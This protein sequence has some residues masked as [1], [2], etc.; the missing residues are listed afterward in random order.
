M[1][2]K[3]TIRE[4][5]LT[6]FALKNRNTVLLVILMIIAFGVLSYDNLPKELFPDVKFPTI[7]VQTTYPGNPPE[8]IENLITR[9]LEKELKAVKGIKELRSISVQD[10]SMIFVEFSFDKE[11]DE[12]LADVKDEVDKVLS[13]LPNDLL[14]DPQ[15][16]DV[17]F[18][19]FPI[20]NINLSGDFSVDELKEY[21]DYLQDELETIYEVSK[22]EM[23]GINEKE[24]Q[25][26][27]NPHKLDALQLSFRDI[28]NAVSSENVS[29]SGGEIRMGDTRR[30]IRVIGEFEEVEEMEDIIVKNE[31]G[32]IV[33][34]KD[35][36]DVV[37]GYEEPKSFARENRQ[38]VVS[39]QVIK[40]SGENL[41]RATSQVFEIIKTSKEKG[42]IPENLSIS[43]TNDQSK[44]IKSQLSNLENSM[45]IGVLFVVLVLFFF[46]GMRNALLVGFAIPMSMLLS[47][48]ILGTMGATIN[49]IIL[50]SLILALGMLVDNAIV[51]VENIYR[52][53]DQGYEVRRAAWQAVGEIA[54]PIISSTATTLAAFFPLLFW[55]DLM[56]EFMK[57]LPITLIIVLSSS[58][59]VALVITPV[60]AT[61]FIK[62]NSKVKKENKKLLSLI[63]SGFVVLSL[64]F[65]L[66][67]IYTIA[68]LLVIAAIFVF[69]HVLIMKR[70]AEWFQYVFLRWLE[71]VYLRLIRFTLTGLR[72]YFF[73][74]LTVILLFSTIVFYFLSK[75]SILFFPDNEPQYIN[76]YAELPVG[77]D[78]TATDSVMKQIENK[79]YATID[80]YD[81]IVESVLTTVGKGVQRENEFSLGNNPNKGMI[82]VK[83]VDYEDRGGINTSDIMK[84]LTNTFHNS[85][86]GIEFFLEKNSMG[87]PVGNPINVQLSGEKMPMLIQISD[88]LIQMINQANIPG[89][90]GLKIDVETGNPEVRVNINREKARRY[91][92]STA[93]IAMNIRTALFGKEISDFKVGE[94]EYPIQLRLKEKYRHNLSS[95]LNQRITFRDQ[96]TGRIVQVPISAVADF[97]FDTSYDIINRT[98]MKRV[99]NI[100]SN[101][102]EGYNANEINQK[103]ENIIE[104]YEMPDGYQYSFT[105]EQEEQAKSM[106]FLTRALG[107]A[108]A[109]ILIILVSQFNSFVKPFIIIISVLFSTIGVFGGL[110]TFD[111][112]FV[113]IMTGIGIV[114]LAGV[115]VNNAIVLID[116]IDYLKTNR[117]N[118]LGMDEDDALPLPE[119]IQAIIRGGKTR[120][121]P[122]LLTA[123]TTILGLLPMA[124]GVNISFDKLLSDFK[125]EFYFGGDNADFWGPMSWTV[126]FGLAFATLLTLFIVPSMYLIANKVKLKA[127]GKLRYE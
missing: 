48:V 45:I 28:E 40:K 92:L 12:A 110:A 13:E 127:Q 77:T 89:I 121:R 51:V 29:I 30:A 2:K 17:D 64:P 42:F 15:V 59:F 55:D 53:V 65:Y 108:I 78:V 104:D 102:I 118:E 66:G 10:A 1:A 98:D 123:I 126:I 103:I 94:D 63:A 88:T 111:M 19:E 39:L 122:V 84:E 20:L 32:K 60:V 72:P 35:L 18:S 27:V 71:N 112:D 33:Y 52:F 6:T 124:L 97:K 90:E 113:V 56:G 99:I 115:V 106:K 116:Y 67:G 14:T 81:H 50:F 75:P 82:T 31:N 80:P 8:D 95:L 109:L 38:T 36:A 107:I 11:I 91:G 101:V 62:S 69:L 86:P 4:F 37:D 74:G 58:L 24:I 23:K 68:N 16:M 70:I 85:Y 114:S 83:F 7:L 5:K 3:S 100:F 41:L 79:L 25:I 54:M 43:Y 44:M 49:M 96:A 47:F 46:L 93:Q 61:R 76:I 120:L 73:L 26:N 117:K 9:P 105:G 119:I 22:V 87:P 57:Y 21:A 125:P 34:L